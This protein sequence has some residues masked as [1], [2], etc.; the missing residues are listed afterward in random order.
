MQMS[1]MILGVSGLTFT[2][3]VDVV[4]FIDGVNAIIRIAIR[5]LIVEWKGRHLRTQSNISKK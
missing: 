2:K 3:F 5:P 1:H 4:I